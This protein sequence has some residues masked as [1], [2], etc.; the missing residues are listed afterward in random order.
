MLCG[1]LPRVP[2]EVPW[3]KGRLHAVPTGRTRAGYGVWS[4][5]VW[6]ERSEG[7]SCCKDV[8]HPK[9]DLEGVRRSSLLPKKDFNRKKGGRLP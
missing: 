8:R 3:L 1:L 2:P 5:G 6:E 9:D 4:E 7:F